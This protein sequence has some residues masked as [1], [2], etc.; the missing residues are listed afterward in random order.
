MGKGKTLVRPYPLAGVV[1]TQVLGVPVDCVA[2]E[3]LEKVLDGLTDYAQTSEGVQLVF[4]RTFD[5]LRARR[6]PSY[7][8]ALTNA[9]LVLPVSKDISNALVK[10]GHPNAHRYYPTDTLVK[11]LGWLEARKGGLYFLGASGRDITTIEQRIRRTFP[12]ARIVGRYM[13]RFPKSTEP[14]V[15]TAIKK[16]NP[17]LL[18]VGPGLVGRD[19]WLSR[20]R[21]ILNNGLMVYSEDFF[22]YILGKSHRVN[23]VSFRAGREMVREIQ[24][25][26]WKMAGIGLIWWFRFRVLLVRTFRRL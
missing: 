23:K 17:T 6:D 9:G 10:L 22:G 20:R 7:R 26:P 4:L 19:K 3:N 2:P 12:G 16:S 8:E 11:I 25:A 1:R 14:K 5:V 18:L 15:C 13:G 21:S 24:K